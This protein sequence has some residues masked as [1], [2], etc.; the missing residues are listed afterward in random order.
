MDIVFQCPHCGQELEVDS[1]AAGTVFPCPS[2]SEDIVVPSEMP[3]QEVESIGQI[4]EEPIAE[5]APPTPPPALAPAVPPPV[6]ESEEDSKLSVPFSEEKTKELIKKPQKPLEVAA[7]EDQK[8]FRI[9]TIRRAD[10]LELDKDTFDETVSEFIQ[11]VDQDHI[12]AMHPVNY[13]TV[14]SVTQ[15]IVNDYGI[16]IVFRG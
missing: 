11:K 7:R 12:I 15:K 3:S 2:C 14:D 16:L 10:C 8:V 4:E 6:Q 9:K 5:A 13:S 1:E